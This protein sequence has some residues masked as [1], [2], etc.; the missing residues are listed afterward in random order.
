MQH[1]GISEAE[2]VLNAL[3]REIA[4]SPSERFVTITVNLANKLASHLGR[5]SAEA[6]RNSWHNSGGPQQCGGITYYANPHHESAPVEPV[7]PVA[8]P[9]GPRLTYKAIGKMV[10]IVVTRHDD[11]GLVADQTM[12][13]VGVLESFSVLSTSTDVRLTGS[14]AI[15]I[16]WKDT[17]DYTFKV[18]N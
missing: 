14:G 7:T 8:R 18:L 10:E 1:S 15:Q 12:T 9:K 17:K 11:S 13:H 2:D 4:A 16:A 5:L 3:D 6:T